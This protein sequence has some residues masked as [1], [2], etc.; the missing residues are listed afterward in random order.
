MGEEKKEGCFG[1]EPM[2]KKASFSAL[3]LGSVCKERHGTFGLTFRL[4][5]S[6]KKKRK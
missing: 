3:Y 6:L 2:D 1:G 5:L 4:S